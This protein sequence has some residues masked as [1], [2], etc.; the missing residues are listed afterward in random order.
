MQV[1]VRSEDCRACRWL[2]GMRILSCMQVIVRSEDYAC[3]VSHLSETEERF[4]CF[5]FCFL[6]GIFGTVGGSG[7]YIFSIPETS[8]LEPYNYSFL[9]ATS[10]T[11]FS[12]LEWGE[13]IIL[14]CSTQHLP[15]YSGKQI[16]RW[17][18]LIFSSKRSFL[19]RKRTMEVA[20]KNLWLQMLLNRCK[21]SCMRF[22]G[23]NIVANS[24]SA[25]GVDV[26]LFLF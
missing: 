18:F 4:L 13:P 21:D 10:L 20:A 8:E 12:P 9:K 25:C 7:I 23:G 3:G 1:T 15:S 17:T 22:W 14:V 26:C 24:R 2:S 11:C 6:V 5:H 19:L 16:L